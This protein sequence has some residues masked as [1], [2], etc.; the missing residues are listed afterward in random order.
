MNEKPYAVLD[1]N[2]EMI[3]NFSTMKSSIP[4]SKMKKAEGRDCFELVNTLYVWHLAEH[5][6][7]LLVFM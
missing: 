7:R 2:N 4:F 1:K 5:I 3:L 6:T